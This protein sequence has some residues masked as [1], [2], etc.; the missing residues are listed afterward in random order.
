MADSCDVCG[1]KNAA[2]KGSGGISERGRRI[3]LRVAEPDDLRRDVI[4]AETASV[5]LPT[6]HASTSDCAR[7]L[8][9]MRRKVYEAPHE[10]QEN[11]GMYLLVGA[12]HTEG[13]AV[14]AATND[15][16]GKTCGLMSTGHMLCSPGKRRLEPRSCDDAPRVP[17]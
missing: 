9:H 11:H 15:A 6:P 2:V 4:K 7:A 5:P 14:H 12:W 10:V 8:D 3:T 17:A 13:Q 16:K 1:Y